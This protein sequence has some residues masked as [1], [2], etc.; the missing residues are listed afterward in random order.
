MVAC[1][2]SVAA[3][4]DAVETVVVVVEESLGRQGGV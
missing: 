1:V 3:A 4:M 2:D